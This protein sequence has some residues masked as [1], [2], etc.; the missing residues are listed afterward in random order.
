VNGCGVV[1]ASTLEL[2]SPTNATRLLANTGA[3]LKTLPTQQVFAQP[4]WANQQLIVAT[5]NQ[6]LLS[7]GLG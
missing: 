4:V 6:G 1:A 5:W 7:Y 2:F 3:I